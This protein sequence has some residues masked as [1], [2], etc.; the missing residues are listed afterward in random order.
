MKNKGFTLTELLVVVVILGIITGISVPLIRSLSTTFEKKKYINY[1]DSL[2]SASKLYNDSYSEDLFGHNEYGC[3]YITY[4]ELVKRNLLKDIQIDGVSCNSDKTYVRVVKQKDKYGYAAFLSCGKKTDGKITEA[5]TKI[6]SN[7]P[8]M[9]AASCTG[10]DPSNIAI[11]ATPESSIAFDKKRKTTKL[12]LTS[13][14][15]I[16]TNVVIYTKWS[17]DSNGYTSNDGWEKTNFKITGDQQSILLDGNPVTS[18]SKQ[19]ITPDGGAEVD[20]SWIL[21]VRV[22]NLSDLY[23][24]KWKNS[25]DENNKVISFSPFN[26]DTIP[27]TISNF[28][29]ASAASN[30]NDSKVRVT[31]TGSDN[32]TATEDLKMCIT[33]DANGCKTASDYEKY[34]SS[35]DI[36]LSTSGSN[37]KT[38]YVYLKDK[39][40]NVAN[41]SKNYDVQGYVKVVDKYCSNNNANSCTEFK[42]REFRGATGTKETISPSSK[43]GY[44]APSSYEVTYGGSHTL[45]F[46]HAVQGVTIN[47]S[48]YYSNGT[49]AANYSASYVDANK[50]TVTYPGA[51]KMV[52]WPVTASPTEAKQCFGVNS[53]NVTFN[54][55]S[56]SKEYNGRYGTYF[57]SA[58][59]NCNTDSSSS[60]YGGIREAA[61]LVLR[62]LIRVVYYTDRTTPYG[63]NGHNTTK[64]LDSELKIEK[65]PT[66]TGYTFK[67]WQAYAY[68][69]NVYTACKQNNKNVYIKGDGSVTIGKKYWNIANSSYPCPNADSYPSSSK[70]NLYNSYELTVFLEAV[71]QLNAWR[72]YK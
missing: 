72:E 36:T 30:Y 41:T 62:P 34:N 16:D 58:F 67:A 40:G 64:V 60:G 24:N 1:A 57:A 5:T 52:V 44:I 56:G 14:T 26:V 31:F 63:S 8:D 59:R 17:K 23:G 55:F 32:H 33:E 28:T 38:I 51:S 43:S 10:V 4:D 25:T 48:D 70:T 61:T 37:T 66:K 53:G 22:D 6:P 49:N 15:G 50:M 71:W 2:L 7:I 19:L 65:A 29:I 39:T 9:D 20:G 13:Y 3:A 21:F 45:T 35:K 46:Y 27:P 68:T 11:S 18:T 12:T 69:G 42:T 47:S 54:S